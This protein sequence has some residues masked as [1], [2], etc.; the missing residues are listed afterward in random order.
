M[1]TYL[2]HRSLLRDRRGDKLQV[3]QSVS[4]ILPSRWNGQRT[5]GGDQ[6]DSDQSWGKL[7]PY[8]C[9]VYA[10]VIRL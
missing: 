6:S 1:L 7:V 3:C 8:C 10:E 4:H 5:L 9:D 2:I